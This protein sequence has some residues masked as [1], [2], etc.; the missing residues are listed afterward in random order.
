MAENNQG[1]EN[2][3]FLEESANKVSK[4]LAAKE[5]EVKKYSDKLDELSQKIID[6]QEEGKIE[7]LCYNLD[8]DF[9]CS[10]S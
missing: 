2:A 8:Y 10:S 5:K 4:K 3:E 1:R 9:S 7:I 6:E